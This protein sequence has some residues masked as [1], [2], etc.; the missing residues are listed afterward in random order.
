MTDQNR[1]VFER[2]YSRARQPEDLPWHSAT[3]PALL[4]KALDARE[5]SGTALDVGC[6]AGTHSMY[7]AKR[8]YQVTAVD[9]MPRAVELLREQARIGGLDITAI[10]ADVIAWAADQP[11]DVVLDSGCLHS[12]GRQR[13][14]AYRQRLL[15]W[16]APG[17]DYILVHYGRRG[18][19]DRWPIGP[20]RIYRS[21]IEALFAP[22][23]QLLEYEP[24]TL[25]GM[26][27]FMGGSALVGRYWLRRVR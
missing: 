10:Q 19:W 11:F 21:A 5:T 6:G 8:D 14:A 12:L 3:P 27:L 25:S 18:W 4:A 1:K 2:L 24:E 26:P 23:L 9:F 17:G 16:L 20:D 22:E 7:M 13:Q 15:Q